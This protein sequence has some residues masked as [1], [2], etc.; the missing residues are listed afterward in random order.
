MRLR[1]LLAPVL[2]ASAL[3]AHAST[4]AVFDAS[5]TFQDGS[6]LSGTLT[7]NT[8]TGV[9]TAVDLII[10]SPVSSTQTIVAAQIQNLYGV[11]QYGVNARNADSTLDFDFGIVD[12]T[13]LVGYTGGAIT[14][15]NLFNKV[16]HMAFDP[17]TNGTLTPAAAP[18]PSSLVLLGTGLLGVCGALRRRFV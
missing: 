2:L 8:T 12:G 6:V 13:S 17:I 18:E 16:T 9:I 7:I 1:F 11:G 3:A 4:I 10:G 15:S 5:G 14:S